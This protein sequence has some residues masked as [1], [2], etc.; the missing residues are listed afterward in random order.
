MSCS[1]GVKVIFRCCNFISISDESFLEDEYG[2]GPS[3]GRIRRPRETARDIVNIY[4]RIGDLEMDA[5]TSSQAT[6]V[7]FEPLRGHIDRTNSNIGTQTKFF[8]KEM[9]RVED[10]TNTAL[11]NTTAVQEQ[12]DGLRQQTSDIHQ[13]MQAMKQHSE[14]LTQGLTEAIAELKDLRYHHLPASFDNWY[15]HRIGLKPT[16][17][18][19]ETEPSWNPPVIPIPN[20]DI[21]S[22]VQSLNSLPNRIEQAKED[23]DKGNES[24]ETVSSI[25]SSDLFRKYC[26]LSPDSLIPERVGGYEQSSGES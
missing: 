25:R 20:I 3:T 23:T 22:L 24:N 11:R 6:S 7:S 17:N 12:V 16:I 14:A 19:N 5:H 15:N 26:Q 10:T 8:T 2:A 4:M 18:A 13:F 9:R 1:A 21:P